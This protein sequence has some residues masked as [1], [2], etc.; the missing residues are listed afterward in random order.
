MHHL[1]IIPPECGASVEYGYKA[2]AA[3][4][5]HDPQQDKHT[6]VFPKPPGV[7]KRPWKW[8]RC[9]LAGCH[10]YLA[11]DVNSES[12]VRWRQRG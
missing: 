8:A 2:K 12:G 11:R 10:M 9:Y 7:G 5:H 4:P 6:S 1:E 3:D